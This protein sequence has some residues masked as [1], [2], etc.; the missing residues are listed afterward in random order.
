MIDT[1]DT[2]TEEQQTNWM[3]GWDGKVCRCGRG[4]YDGEEVW[5]VESGLN[6]AIVFYKTSYCTVYIVCYHGY[7]TRIQ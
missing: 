7:R 1:E 2:P 6:D 5:E 4:G 3:S